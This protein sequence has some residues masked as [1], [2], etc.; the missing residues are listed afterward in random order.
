MTTPSN[1]PPP[2]HQTSPSGATCTTPPARRLVLPVQ[3]PALPPSYW[4]SL[5]CIHG[6]LR[7]EHHR[8]PEHGRLPVPAGP[9]MRRTL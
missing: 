7:H 3:R 1:F 9:E 5:I 2:Q 4:R 6:N 8:P